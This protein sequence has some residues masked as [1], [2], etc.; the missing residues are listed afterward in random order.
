MRFKGAMAVG[1][2][3]LFS[4]YSCTENET[5]LNNRYHEN[6]N[7]FSMEEAKDFFEKKSG[8]LPVKLTRGLNKPDGIRFPPGEFNAVW[9]RAKKIE[10]ENLLFYDLPIE[11]QMRYK[12]KRKIT[13]SKGIQTKEIV[14]VYQRLMVVKDMKTQKKAYYITTFIPDA[15]STGEVG[16]ENFVRGKNHNNY[17][18]LVLYINPETNTP[19]RVN[20]YV[21][22][23]KTGGVF[24]AG[25]IK[26][27]VQKVQYAQ[28]LIGD[29]SIGQKRM[30]TAR[31]Y[32]ESDWGDNG[33]G[34]RNEHATKKHDKN[35]P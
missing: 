20:R 27:A 18:G 5:I 30:A 34:D 28:E 6:A 10:L 1:L 13:D 2:L 12:V 4:F 22:G 17:S 19:I 21:K 7:D 16:C 31:I 15:G 9:D 33:D 3:A 25:D 8:K 11:A 24:L 32:T 23:V 29:I 35:I 26:D 14:R